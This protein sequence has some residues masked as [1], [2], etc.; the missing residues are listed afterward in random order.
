LLCC[1]DLASNNLTGALTD[2]WAAPAAL[3]ALRLLSL[4]GN[5]LS[6]SLPLVGVF[7][8]TLYCWLSRAHSMALAFR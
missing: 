3:P 6:G 5:A 4:A 8:S 7:Q 1:R 2:G